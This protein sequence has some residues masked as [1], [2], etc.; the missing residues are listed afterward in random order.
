M[1]TL[2][3]SKRA[4]SPTKPQNIPATT[5]TTFKPAS[6]VFN[7]VLPPK[8]PVYPRRVARADEPVMSANGTPLKFPSAFM[9]PRGV[10]PVLDEQGEENEHELT[11]KAGGFLVRRDPSGV[12]MDSSSASTAVSS[13]TGTLITISTSKGQTVQFDPLMASPGSLDRIPDLTDSAKKQIRDDTAR[14][15][16]ALHKWRI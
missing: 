2:S 6:T 1:P 15:V 13:S 12:S 14:I 8:T 3:P 10:G 11:A 4:I 9:F 16:Q 5:T 7:P